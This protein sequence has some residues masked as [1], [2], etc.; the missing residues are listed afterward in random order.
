MSEGD[1]GYLLY[2]NAKIGHKHFGGKLMPSHVT[3]AAVWHL[4]KESM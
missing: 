2:N 4:Y 3:K 1:Y